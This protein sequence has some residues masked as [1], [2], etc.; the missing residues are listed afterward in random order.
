[1]AAL[2]GGPGA[3]V[4]ALTARRE[5]AGSS[6]PSSGLSKR[7]DR[8]GAED[9]RADGFFGFFVTKR[10]GMLNDRNLLFGRPGSG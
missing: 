8:P 10:F 3:R 1:M 5:A 7:R 4:T 6:A 9:G 2:G